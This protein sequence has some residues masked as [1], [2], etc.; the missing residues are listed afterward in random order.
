MAIPITMNEFVHIAEFKDFRQ[1]NVWIVLKYA[2]TTSCET[3]F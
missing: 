1:S 3:C 2:R